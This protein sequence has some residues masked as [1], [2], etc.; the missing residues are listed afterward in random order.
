MTYSPAEEAFGLGDRP[1]DPTARLLA[2]AP[3]RMERL[4]QL[5]LLDQG[6]DPKLDAFAEDVAD[7]AMSLPG[8]DGPPTVMVNL[9][10]EKQTLGGLYIPGAA[11]SEAVL[12]P[13]LLEGVP[14]HTGYC[15]HVLA[16]GKGLVLDDVCDYPRFAGNQ[17]VDKLSVRTYCGVPLIDHTNTALGTLCL[18]GQEPRSWGRPGLNLAKE[19]AAELISL[20]SR[21]GR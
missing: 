6:R 8:G 17:I 15:P 20:I 10:G 5:G 1:L 18:V 7:A 16:R 3:R 13:E 14:L 19:K 11:D 9:I 12:P 4:R 21:R 2:D